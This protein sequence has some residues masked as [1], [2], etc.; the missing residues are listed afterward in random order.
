[1][2]ILFGE[3][4]LTSLIFLNDQCVGLHMDDV[5]ADWNRTTLAS[6]SPTGPL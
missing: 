2:S 1:M 3:N 6:P 5:V 4:S